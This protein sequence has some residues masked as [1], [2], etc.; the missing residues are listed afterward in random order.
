MVNLMSPD[1]KSVYHF[2]RR[3]HAQG[4]REIIV[5]RNGSLV[6]MQ[7]LARAR[8]FL[9]THILVAAF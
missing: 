4:L 9:A 2:W 7:R 8:G 5:L 3:Y 1:V 6:I